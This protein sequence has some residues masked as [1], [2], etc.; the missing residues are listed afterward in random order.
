MVQL[1]S[2]LHRY[3]QDARD[4]YKTKELANSGYI[5]ISAENKNGDK[6]SIEGSAPHVIQSYNQYCEK[7]AITQA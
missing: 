4:V 7:K 3:Q 6:L 5:K 1:A 2:T